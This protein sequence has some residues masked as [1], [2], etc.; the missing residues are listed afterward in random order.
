MSQHTLK[1]L[2]EGQIVK[3]LVKADI[4]MPTEFVYS[5]VFNVLGN[6]VSLFDMASTDSDNNH[7][8]VI[9]IS[10]YDGSVDVLDIIE[11]DL[12]ER[13]KKEHPEEFV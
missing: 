11:L 12:Q 9:D 7:S 8:W 6:Q 2:K 5:Y 1:D 3:L 13:L 10:E 4:D